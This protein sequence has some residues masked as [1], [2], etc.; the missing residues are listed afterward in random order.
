MLTLAHAL[1]PRIHHLA[2]PLLSGCSNDLSSR[3]AAT[4]PSN[5][6]IFNRRPT[7]ENRSRLQA[8]LSEERYLALDSYQ[9]FG[10]N[11]KNKEQEATKHTKDIKLQDGSGTNSCQEQNSCLENQLETYEWQLKILHAVL[12][13]SGEQEREQ[14]LKDHSG[15]ICTLIHSISDKVK[16]E[17]RTDLNEL[18]EKHLKSI[19]EQ[20]QSEAEELRRIHRE[21]TAALNEVFAS[22][23][24]TL[25][26]EIEGLTSELK[27]FKELKRRVEESTLKRDLQRNIETH[28]SPGEFWEQEQ[29]SLLFVIEMKRQHL[30]EQRSKLLQMQ[31]MQNED[32]KVRM[33]NYQ[34]LIQQ[35]SREQNELQEALEQ[36][37]LQKQKLSQEK[38]E[39]LF[40]LLQQRTDSCSSFQLPPVLHT[41]LSPS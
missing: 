5:F 26:E 2:V 17:V 41:H 33:E 10:S 37:A 16:T 1:L 19:S 9:T 28:G 24:K 40:K 36:Q 39:L 14:L 13:A 8:L 3:R 12:T 18:H 38:E 6:S 22:S 35:L 7:A 30:Q 32:F 11:K 20:Y 27:L 34:S 25:K 21:E 29:E 4:G 23:E 31:S 15:D